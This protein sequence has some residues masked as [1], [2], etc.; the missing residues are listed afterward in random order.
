VRESKEV[1][2][3]VLAIIKKAYRAG[4]VSLNDAVAAILKFN[5]SF[6]RGMAL[7]LLGA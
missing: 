7:R 5:K 6:D 1:S 4:R 2:V 3:K